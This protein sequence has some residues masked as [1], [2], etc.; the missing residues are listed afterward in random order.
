MRP[1]FITGLL[2]Y[3]FDF[4]RP[5][6][7]SVDQTYRG[8]HSA[9]EISLTLNTPIAYKK[10]DLIFHLELFLFMFVF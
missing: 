8:T 5:S 6:C 10:L 9:T 7:K 1:G 4:S 3:L 2:R